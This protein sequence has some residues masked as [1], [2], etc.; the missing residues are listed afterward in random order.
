VR[1]RHSAI[2]V[3]R[4]LEP[5]DSDEAGHAFQKEAGH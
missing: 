1:F 4:S 2:S 3:R 5:A